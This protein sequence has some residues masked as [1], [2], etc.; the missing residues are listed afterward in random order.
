VE[1][2][3]PGKGKALFFQEVGPSKRGKGKGPELLSYR[4]VEFPRS[5]QEDV[6]GLPEEGVEERKGKF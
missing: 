5:W 4:E 1:L 2:E 3:L 6:R